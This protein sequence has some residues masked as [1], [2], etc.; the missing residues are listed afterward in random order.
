MNSVIIYGSHYG[1][2]KRYA[3]KFSEV[4]KILVANYKKIKN[5]S[6]YNLIIHFGGLYAGG[7]KGLKNTVKALN[8]NQRLVIV[9]VGLADVSDKENT[10]SI[11]KSISRQ[12][13]ENI[14]KNTAVFHLR[15]GIDYEKLNFKHRTMM[16]L[17]YNKAKNL[18]EDKKTAEVR[19]MIDTY[20]SKV[21][22][23]D[24]SSL[25]HIM[26]YVHKFSV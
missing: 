23:V 1:T 18:P 7:V 19:A 12:V 21:D 10:D 22:F 3:E 9:T 17:L 4:T 6:E 2:T 25:N 20:N 11:R 26:D 13:P 16:T 14:L 15:G 8:G 24:Y 5:L